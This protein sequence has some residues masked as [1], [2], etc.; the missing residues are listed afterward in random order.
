[1]ACR[2]VSPALRVRLRLPQSAIP[3][4]VCKED[5]GNT[6][7]HDKSGAAQPPAALLCPVCDQPLEL[8]LLEINE[9]DGGVVKLFTFDYPTGD[10]RGAMRE[11]EVREMFACKVVR[12]LQL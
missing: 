5:G 4:Y 10:Y 6:L 8:S 11:A 3:T 7:Q 2:D 1:V 12:R 9:D